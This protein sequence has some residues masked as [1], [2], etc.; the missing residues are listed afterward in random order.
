MILHGLN[1]SLIELGVLIFFLVIAISSI[2]LSQDRYGPLKPI[3]SAK[4]LT[5]EVQASLDLGNPEVEQTAVTITK[6]YP[7][8]YNLNQV[9]AVYED[10]QI[11]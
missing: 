8:E 2:G 10:Q 7:G 6:D 1:K 9:S 4:N 11:R 3:A 5:A